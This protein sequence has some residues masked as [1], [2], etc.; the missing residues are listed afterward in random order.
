MVDR[1]PL[2]ESINGDGAVA[3]FAA[4][5]KAYLVVPLLAQHNMRQCLF[6]VLECIFGGG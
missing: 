4:P 3:M 6:F 2:L 5:G 1:E